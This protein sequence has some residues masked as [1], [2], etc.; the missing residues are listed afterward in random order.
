MHRFLGITLIVMGALSAVM[1]A[2]IAL[3]STWSQIHIAE[4][5]HSLTGTPQGYVQRTVLAQLS[6]AVFGNNS[7]MFFAVQV[8][9]AL[10]L[11]MAANTA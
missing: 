3:L 8:F 9:T 11:A 6:A 5:V 4:E 1:M 7:V 10:I 2:G